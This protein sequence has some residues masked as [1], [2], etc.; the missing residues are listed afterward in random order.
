[1][2]RY[3]ALMLCLLACVAAFGEDARVS[4]QVIIQRATL[5]PSLSG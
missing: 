4:G 2:S 1:M 3:L 5:Q